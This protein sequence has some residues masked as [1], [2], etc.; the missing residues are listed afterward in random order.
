MIISKFDL[1]PEEASKKHP[2][3]CPCSYRTALSHYVDI[4]TPPRTHVL[5]ELADYASD[6]A[7]KD[8]LLTMTQASEEGKVRSMIALIILNSMYDFN[9]FFFFSLDA[10]YALFY[11]CPFLEVMIQFLDSYICSAWDWLHLVSNNRFVVLGEAVHVSLQMALLWFPAPCL[12]DDLI[13]ISAAVWKHLQIW[14][15]VNSSWQ[16]F[17]SINRHWNFHFAQLQDDS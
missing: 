2:F 5:R 7:E 10:Y 1:I 8:L 12:L 3:P 15:K 4:Q 13:F 14:G 16:E 9:F 17:P 11:A 6:P